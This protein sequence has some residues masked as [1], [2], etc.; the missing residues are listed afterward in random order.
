M[1]R[2]SEHSTACPRDG[3]RRHALA[4]PIPCGQR[5]QDRPRQHIDEGE[6]P[7]RTDRKFVRIPVEVAFPAR[8]NK[9]MPVFAQQKVFEEAGR[10]LF[11]KPVPRQCDQQREKNAADPRQTAPGVEPTA[12]ANDSMRISARH[13]APKPPAPWPAVRGRDR[14]RTAFRRAT[15]NDRMALNP[16]HR[17]LRAPAKIPPSSASCRERARCRS[18]PRRS[19]QRTGNCRRSA[20]RSA[21]PHCDRAAPPAKQSG[22]RSTAK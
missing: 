17:C 5:Q 13:S 3:G 9:A 2:H 19:R 14:R 4:T 7:D 21:P 12:I 22:R 1:L 6:G 16:G 18:S 10:A 20:P 8:R 11:G 15:S